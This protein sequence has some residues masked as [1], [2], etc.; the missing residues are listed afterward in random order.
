MAV[1]FHSKDLDLLRREGPSTPGT[2][3]RKISPKSAATKLCRECFS[4]RDRLDDFVFCR[5]AL[6]KSL[7]C[8]WVKPNIHSLSVREMR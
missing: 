7:E 5:P 3:G 8:V 6:Y 1:L 2:P 4:R